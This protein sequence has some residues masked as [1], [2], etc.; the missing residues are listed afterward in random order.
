MNTPTARLRRLFPL[1]W[2]DTLVTGG[3]FAGAMLLCALLLPLYGDGGYI[4]M[5]FVLAVVL[6]SYWTNG[7]FYGMLMSVS[8]VL[9]VNYLFTYP[10]YHLNF[11]ISGYPIAFVTMLVV[12]LIISTITTQ[13]REKEKLRVGRGGGSGCAP[14]C[15]A[16]F[17]TI[18]ARR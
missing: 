14:T 13:A 5:V 1:S 11:T 8:S 4:S 16:P 17:R 2:R 6:V 18:C 12:S 7:Y 15:C 10:Y 9:C 3:V